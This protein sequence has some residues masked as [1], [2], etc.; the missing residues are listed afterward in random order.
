MKNILELEDEI[1]K[2]VESCANDIELTRVDH[3]TEEEIKDKL[4]VFVGAIPREDLDTLAPCAVVTTLK[5]TNSLDEKR[6][7][8]IVSLAIYNKDTRKGYEEIYNLL[9][10]ISKTL[11]EKAIVLDEYEVLPEYKWELPEVQ[12]YP[13]HGIDITFNILA[14]NTYRRDVDVWE[15]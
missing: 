2:I 10:I 11:I 1:R 14:R 9:E 8:T 5:G 7:N 6:L 12:P 13:I 3:E 15:E 4:Q